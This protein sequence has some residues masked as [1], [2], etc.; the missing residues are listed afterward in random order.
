GTGPKLNFSAWPGSRR[1]RTRGMAHV[2]GAD[3]SRDRALGQMAVADHQLLVLLGAEV[4]SGLQICFNLGLYGLGEEPLGTLPQ[5]VG[6]RVR[7]GMRQH[8]GRS[9]GVD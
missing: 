8:R 4:R 5:H 9:C 7:A 2:D 1:S 6:E 3:A